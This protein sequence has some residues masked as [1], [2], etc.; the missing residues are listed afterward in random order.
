MQVEFLLR[1]VFDIGVEVGE[2]LGGLKVDF[3]VVGV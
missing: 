2:I 1:D 3:A